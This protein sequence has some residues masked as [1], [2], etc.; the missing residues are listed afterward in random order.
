MPTSVS[1]LT[2]K[3]DTISSDLC[4]I[5]LSKSDSDNL[6]EI[7]SKV[8]TQIEIQKELQKT[9]HILLDLPSNK[10]FKY[11]SGRLKKLIEYAYQQPAISDRSRR[12]R[13]LDCEPFIFCGLTYNAS[14]LSNCPDNEFDCLLENV[15]NYIQAQSL[16]S[17]WVFRD[18]VYLVIKQFNN[19]FKISSS[20]FIYTKNY[21]V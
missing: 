12:L 19:P 13:D 20:S 11:G 6:S 3:L 9:A 4:R 8:S 18:D 2:A 1:E 15:G 21:S 5:F 14:H 7:L 17:N 16:P 10:P